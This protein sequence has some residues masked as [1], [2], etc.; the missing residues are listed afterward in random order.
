[1]AVTVGS[2]PVRRP[3]TALQVLTVDDGV[4]AERRDRLATEE[5]MEIRVQ[6]P[7]EDPVAFAV[8]MRTPGNDFE[9]AAGLCFTEGV[10]SSATDVDTIAYCLATDARARPEQQYNI[11]TVRLRRPAPADLRGRRYLANS[12]CGICGKAALD[13]VEVRAAPVDSGPRVAASTLQS[14]PAGLSAHQRIFDQTGGLHAAARFTAAGELIAT[15]EDVGRHNALDK[16]IGHALLAGEI[17]LREQVLLVSGRLSFELVQKAAV[18]GI[19]VLCAVSAPSSLAVEAAE[20][21]GQT[22][23]CFLRGSRFNVYAHPDRI[24]LDA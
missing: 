15:R 6:G 11:V 18:A 12:S 22:V 4:V 21:F 10:V 17:P 2:S 1:V 23:V 24:D 13:E 14:L 5:P 7:G 3:V 9:L 16:L 19:P 20:R 8:A